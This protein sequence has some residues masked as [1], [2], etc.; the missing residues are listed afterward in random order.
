MSKKTR[1]LYL[2][3][4]VGVVIFDQAFQIFGI[5]YLMPTIGSICSDPNFYGVV[6]STIELA[7]FAGVYF[8][9]FNKKSYL[10]DFDQ[11]YCRYNLKKHELFLIGMGFIGLVAVW[12]FFVQK[13]LI[14]IPVFKNS[15]DFFNQAMDLSAGDGSFILGLIYGS[16]LAA[17]ME[18]FLFRGIIHNSLK[19][20]SHSRMFA[21]IFTG[22]LFGLWHGILVQGVYAAIG[23]ILFS[24]IYERTG[25]LSVTI[26]IHFINNF[27]SSV[28]TELDKYVSGLESAFNILSIVF[29]PVLFYYMYK[30]RCDKK[31][32]IE[33]VEGVN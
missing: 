9:F 11:N 23:G 25:K 31:E 5:V 16:L 4:A 12:L 2:L 19:L 26:A 32:C 10:K 28:V 7:I 14:N 22:I 8:Y 6:M 20:F 33:K 3:L 30:M 1:L 21:I 15:Y 24:Y 18:E 13:V 29:V 17:L 27:L